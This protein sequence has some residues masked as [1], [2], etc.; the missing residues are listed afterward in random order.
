[1]SLALTWETIKP[2]VPEETKERIRQIREGE[3]TY[4]SEE[5]EKEFGPFDKPIDLPEGNVIVSFEKTEEGYQISYAEAEAWKRE[6]ARERKKELYAKYPHLVMGG[7][8]EGYAPL[9]P[10]EKMEILEKGYPPVVSSYLKMGIGAQE[11][12]RSIGMLIFGLPIGAVK[13]TI[14]GKG[15]KAGVQE[16]AKLWYPSGVVGP[17][18]M[19]YPVAI[20][21]D[22]WSLVT[23]GEV[24]RTGELTSALGE[25]GWEYATG[26]LLTSVWMSYVVS[27]AGPVQRFSQLITEGVKKGATIT[28]QKL[29]SGTKTLLGPEY[30]ARLLD[31]SWQVSEPFKVTIPSYL[32]QLGASADDFMKYVFGEPYILAKTVYAPNIR[33]LIAVLEPSWSLYKQRYFPRISFPQIG[34]GSLKYGFAEV[35]A[36]LGGLKWAITEPF[37][38]TKFL[39]TLTLPAKLKYSVAEIVAGLGEA[40]WRITEP[41]YTVKFPSFLNLIQLPQKIKYSVAELEAQIRQTYWEL[42]DPLFRAKLLPSL[43]IKLPSRKELF[44]S[45][46]GEEEYYYYRYITPAVARREW[47]QLSASFQKQLLGITES[48]WYQK[49]FHPYEYYVST[50]KP[51]RP[52]ES[53][54]ARELFKR[55]PSV[56]YEY[57]PTP[58][59]KTVSQLIYESPKLEVTPSADIITPIVSATALSTYIFEQPKEKE[60]PLQYRGAKYP[61]ILMPKQWHEL[62]LEITTYPTEKEREKAVPIISLGEVIL[63]SPKEL[64]EQVSR[65]KQVQPQGLRQAQPQVL[66][67]S[68]LLKQILEESPES[69]RR[70]RYEFERKKG[71]RVQKKPIGFEEWFF[72]K[73]PIPTTSQVAKTILGTPSTRR[74]GVGEYILGR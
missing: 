39:P 13:G 1:M 23:G 72:K 73:H 74:K 14:E 34:F 15:W 56:G 26:G 35:Y 6:Q 53:V 64:Q 47:Q 11:E 25:Y 7:M 62:G 45:I 2:L 42:S 31:V 68:Q 17:S 57:T 3:K 27:Q 5:F 50:Y 36:Q 70:K 19:G 49:R 22:V 38:T 41:F 40:K 69:K 61:S 21:Q 48:A 71:K 9:S 8:L 54:V 43:G 51:M 60:M 58:S 65:L 63:Q 12:A 24:G 55:L 66:R 16:Q 28:G 52:M 18:V 67:Q 32:R 30:Y 10:K 44:M 20:G 29:V 33:N 46:F 37:Y 4:T 59:G